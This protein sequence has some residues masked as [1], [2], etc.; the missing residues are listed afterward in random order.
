MIKPTVVCLTGSSS[1]KDEY[2]RIHKEYVLR[3]YIVLTP[4]FYSHTDGQ[5]ITKRQKERLDALYLHYI[6]LSDILCVISPTGYI[7][8]S[9]K[10]DIAHARKQK[11]EVCY[12]KELQFNH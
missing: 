11:K 9:T 2:I 7:G 5:E 3:G 1:F 4:I 12:S 6:N 8:D 10:S